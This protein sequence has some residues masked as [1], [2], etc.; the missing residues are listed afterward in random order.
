MGKLSTKD[1]KKLLDCIK[2]DGRVVIPPT[3]GFDSGVHLLDDNYVVV[4]TDPCLGVPEKWFGYL[5]IH[6]AAS[7]VAL[8]GAKPEFCTINLLGPPSS[9]PQ[10]FQNIMKL[11]CSAADELRLAIVTGHTGTYESVKAPVGICTAYGTVEKNM[12][13]TPA[14]AKAGDCIFCIKPAAL[15]TIVNFALTSKDLASKLF[16]RKRTEELADLV[17]MQSCVNEALLLAGTGGVH[18]MHDATEGGLVAALNE[19]AEVA[20]VGFEIKFENIPFSKEA[21]KLQ[22]HFKLSDTQL[23]SMS[24]TGTFLASVREEA[25]TKIEKILRQRNIAFSVLGQFTADTKRLM[26]KRGVKTLFPRVARDPYGR[27]LSGKV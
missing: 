23:L 25:K 18:A 21:L 9:K 20:G 11:A 1:L 22:Q 26:L 4:S 8:F 3:P 16:G 2:K 17:Q 13:V 6:Y 27:I 24:S 19:M 14:G 12:L 10:T 15:E 7:D 5:L